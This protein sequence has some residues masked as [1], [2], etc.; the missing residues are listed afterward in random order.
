M[1]YQEFNSAWWSAYLVAVNAVAFI[2]YVYDKSVARLLGT[3]RLGF[4]PLRVPE[5]VLV[6]FL[7]F[8]G[9]ALGAYAAMYFAN[10]KTSPAEQE[11]RRRLGKAFLVQVILAIALFKS[12]HVPEDRL[13]AVI[14]SLAGTVVRTVETL[15]TTAGVL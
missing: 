8:P 14:A 15:L 6:W 3:L 13:D 7:A 11:F 12:G 10:H 1:A 2:V 4:L 9:G 5:D